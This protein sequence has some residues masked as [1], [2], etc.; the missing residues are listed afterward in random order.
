MI[1]QIITPC[2]WVDKDAKTVVD[3][4]LSIFKD[5]LAY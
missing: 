1:T 5:G 3:Y 4:Y 2:I